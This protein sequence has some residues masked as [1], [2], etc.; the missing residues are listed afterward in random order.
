MK[1]TVLSDAG[2]VL[3]EIDVPAD[4]AESIRMRRTS[5]SLKGQDSDVAVAKRFVRD[6]VAELLDGS[7]RKEGSVWWDYHMQRTGWTIDQV[8]E[9]G[10]KALVAAPDKTKDEVADV[11]PVVKAVP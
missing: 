5:A 7:Y 1:L 10:L 6:G 11:M 9:D 3:Y 2:E 8:R 4:Y